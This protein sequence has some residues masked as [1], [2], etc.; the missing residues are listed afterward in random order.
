MSLPPG[1]PDPYTV[2]GLAAPTT[3]NQYELK[4]IRQAYRRRALELHPDK[5]QNDPQAAAKFNRLAVVLE[6]L[7][8]ESN[9]DKYDQGLVEQAQRRQRAAAQDVEKKRLAAELK[10]REAAYK[11][12]RAA[13]SDTQYLQQAFKS[14]AAEDP[15]GSKRWEKLRKQAE[16]DRLVLKDLA[17]KKRKAEEERVE[18]AAASGPQ[19]EVDADH[20]YILTLHWHP[21]EKGMGA[22]SR[23]VLETLLKP[24]YSI[25][26]CDG[27]AGFAH[28]QFLS[29]AAALAAAM[30]FTVIEDDTVSFISSGLSSNATFSA[31]V[32]KKPRGVSRLGQVKRSIEDEEEDDKIH[33]S[34]MAKELAKK[35]A[36]TKMK[37]EAAKRIAT[38]DVISSDEEGESEPVP[39]TAQSEAT[40]QSFRPLPA[41]LMARLKLPVLKAA[42]APAVPSKPSPSPPTSSELP[43]EIVDDTEDE[44]EAST[45][46]LLRQ[47]VLRKKA[48]LQL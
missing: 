37:E 47:A 34:R 10:R 6:Y 20:F 36:L 28:V 19:Y 14:R 41:S 48:R 31:R 25:Q 30:T 5:N 39:S 45:V 29:Q 33:E 26:R 17:N 35:E 7:S 15:E 11:A 38:F 18:K 4:D 40:P 9:R 8:S 43:T 2:L 23:T 46:A 32:V 24:P 1:I 27:N 44:L 22:R 21:S 3:P 42:S 13:Q 16:V 12:A